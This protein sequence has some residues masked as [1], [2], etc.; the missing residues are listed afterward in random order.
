MFRD[1]RTLLFTAIVLI[2]I[3]AR[4]W[5]MADACLWFDE[6]FSVHA[7]EHDWS[8]MFWF[9]A[10]DLIHP[11]LFY[12]LLK[13]WILIGG[14]SVFWLRLLPVVFSALAVVPLYLFCREMKFDDRVVGLAL[15][16]LAIN[17]T[18]IKYAQLVRMYSLLMMLSLV[19]LWLFAR[20]FN[21]GKNLTALIIVNLV[22]IYTHYYGWLVVGCEVM[23]VVIFQ[24]FKWRGMAV[25]TGILGVLFLPWLWFV[26]KAAQSGS[27]LSQNISW[28]P[29]PGFA[30]IGTYI[31][32]LTEPFYFQVSSEEPASYYVI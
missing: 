30:E 17:G 5:R 16:L 12:V 2:Y 27:E 13:G 8:G 15:F 32:D 23:A 4:V 1:R 19:S 20:F 22:M 6:I 29:R 25:M 18:F 26:N 31:V 10:Q 21:R 11:P 9:V 28:I 14:E 3:L 24:R 7:A